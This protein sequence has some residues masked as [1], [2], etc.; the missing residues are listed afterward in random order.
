MVFIGILE[1]SF[2]KEAVQ[3]ACWIVVVKEFTALSRSS[4]VLRDML[5]SILSEIIWRKRSQFTGPLMND[6][7]EG[8]GTG[9]SETLRIRGLWSEE[10]SFRRVMEQLRGLKPLWIKKSR[11]SGLRLGSVGQ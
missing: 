4:G 5:R 8:L 9:S 10:S 11:R 7:G 1:E 3:A 6:G 2:G